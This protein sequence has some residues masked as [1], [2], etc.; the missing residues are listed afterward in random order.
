MA[1]SGSYMD[2]RCL[3]VDL[4]SRRVKVALVVDRELRDWRSFNT[5]S[6][7]RLHSRPRRA[8]QVD[9][10]SPAPFGDGPTA[11]G[12]ETTAPPGFATTPG[13]RG[14]GGTA[15]LTVDFEA[16]GFTRYD[17]V[18][19]T[20]YGRNNLAVEG[21]K[22]VSEVMAHAA[23]AVA[24]SG[25]TDFANLD[26]G[27]QDFKLTLVEG[28]IVS[29]MAANPRCAASSGRFL[30]AM[31]EVLDMGLEELGGFFEDPLPIDSTCSVFA[32]T[33]VV[34]LLAQGYP[35][36]RIA[37]GVNLALVRKLTPL[38]GP[39]LQRAD[40]IVFTGGCAQSG[41]IRR[42]LEAELGKDVV[43][44]EHPEANGAFGAA[45]VE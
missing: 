12:G 34:G 6:F 33:E 24:Q 22:V 45:L 36:E 39:I 23:G 30:E 31:A 8:A 16:L 37:A 32:E 9:D 19:S 4:G 13:A 3:G 2:D 20:G 14:G 41:A 11:V 17:R 1:L 7:Y 15:P 38:A 26:M 28:S 44:P 5:P 21:A 29:D 25:L 35:V 18:A 10:V 42:L 27:G 40:R 43:V